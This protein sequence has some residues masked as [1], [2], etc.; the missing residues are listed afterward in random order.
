MQTDLKSAIRCVRLHQHLCSQQPT[1]FAL[2]ITRLVSSLVSSYE[3]NSTSSGVSLVEKT[4]QFPESTPMKQV[5][6]NTY[7]QPVC[8]I[9]PIKFDFDRGFGTENQKFYCFNQFHT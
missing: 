9:Y 6:K 4:V 8:Y 3:K 7:P 5:L 1:Y 2:T